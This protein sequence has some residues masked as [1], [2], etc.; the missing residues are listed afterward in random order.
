LEA[1]GG[2]IKQTLIAEGY[3]AAKP[4]VINVVELAQSFSKTKLNLVDL[5]LDSVCSCAN[6]YNHLWLSLAGK[7]WKSYKLESSDN[8]N[9]S[10]SNDLNGSNLEILE[11]YSTNQST[12]DFKFM[13]SVL[14]G[15]EEIRSSIRENLLV[16][17]N[18]FLR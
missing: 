12:S 1:L 6:W 15:Q 5:N 2:L 3:R 10:S 16:V 9:Q 8:P 13:D 14:I 7:S 4:I 11:S 18:G 17:L